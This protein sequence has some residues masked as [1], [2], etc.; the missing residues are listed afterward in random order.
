M[1]LRCNVHCISYR[2]LPCGK[3]GKICTDKNVKNNSVS[4]NEE[5]VITFVFMQFNLTKGVIYI[6][7][8]I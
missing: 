2:T 3:E 6:Y 7:K 4:F 8:N 1:Y 5:K